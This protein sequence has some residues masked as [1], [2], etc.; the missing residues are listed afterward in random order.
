MKG[1]VLAGGT[2][3]RLYPITMGIS[4]QLIPIYNKPMVYY[5]ISTLML[6]GI[7]DIL[8]ITTPNDRDA[9]E[10]LLGDGSRFGA[11]LTYIT[12]DQPRGLADSF[13]LGENF[14]GS[15]SVALILGDNIFYGAGLGTSLRAL[16]DVSGG[17][18]FAYKVANPSAYGVIEFDNDMRAVSIEEKPAKPKSNY[19]IPG[20][21]FFDNSVIDVAKSIVP[22]AR[23]ELEV[24]DINAH[25]LAAGR[26][27]VTVL[28][29]G[30]AWLDTGT[31]VSMIQAS[32]FVRVVSE[33]QGREIGC[34]E[35]IA[36]ERGW[37]DDDQ[38]RKLAAPMAK[39]AYGEYLLRLLE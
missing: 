12:Q 19:V 32:E 23:G 11:R 13:I 39:S 15:D 24:S 6:A 8:I 34:L 33:R 28:D 31:V 21:Y 1:I 22:S 10:R 37:I 38:L 2:G 18:I 3:T 16:A 4:K 20:L 7:R 9:F 36:W 5:P 26:L 29:R 27:K 14:I 35:E 17:H 30:T 25:Y